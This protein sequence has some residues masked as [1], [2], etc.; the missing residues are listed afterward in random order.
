MA[1]AAR[2]SLSAVAAIHATTA[3]LETEKLFDATIDVANPIGFCAD[4]NAHLLSELHSKFV[5][6]CYKGALVLRILKVVRAGACC[7]CNSNGSGEATVDVQFLAAVRV[8]ARWDILTGVT[9][10]HVSHLIGGHYE[11]KEGGPAA[12]TTT[13]QAF[14]V[15]QPTRGADAL[16]IGQRIA[17]RVLKAEHPPRQAAVAYGVLLTCERAA[18]VFRVRGSLDP[19]AA[20]DLMGLAD[21][22]ADELAL[23]AEVARARPAELAFFEGLLYA[24]GAP[25]GARGAA[26]AGAGAGAGAC[27]GAA[28][29]S[30]RVAA[31]EGGPEWVGPAPLMALE[32]GLVAHSLVELVRKAAV[33]PV[34]V[35]GQWSRPLCLHRSSPLVAFAPRVSRAAATASA[36]VAAADAVDEPPRVVFAMMLK[37]ILD[38]LVATRELALEYDDV[39][40]PKYAGLWGMMRMAQIP[41][42]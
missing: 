17:V 28:T 20:A 5:D 42:Q 21:R 27:A 18:P 31:W 29:L 16:A 4:K 22:V 39:H 26:A 15:L 38:F 25:A 19:A 2:S 41:A 32:E 37:N 36:T 34:S 35:A 30:H 1:D 33:A 8:F 23:R 10:R 24:Y 9:V 7:I 12:A 14:V 13:A 6:R 3:S 11:P 40:H